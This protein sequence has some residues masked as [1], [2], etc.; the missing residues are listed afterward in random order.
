MKYLVF[1]LIVLFST[2]LLAQNWTSVIETEVDVSTATGV[3]DVFANGHGLHVIY[4]EDNALKYC[5]MDVEGNLYAGSP[6]TLESYSAVV[7]PSISGDANTIYVLYKKSGETSIK[8]MYSTN[9]GSN[10]STLGSSPTGSNADFIESIYSEGKLHVTWQVSNQVKYS[11]F[12]GSSWSSP[13]TVSSTENGYFPRIAAWNL[14]NE[15]KVYFYYQNSSSVSK[16]REYNITNNSWGNIQTAFSVSNSTPSGFAV[17]GSK[18]ALFYNYYDAPMYYFQWVIRSKSNNSLLCTRT[19]EPSYPQLLYSTTTVDEH[20]HSVFWFNWYADE[21]EFPG[22]WR[23]R[24]DDDCSIDEVYVNNY[25]EQQNVHFINTSA[26]SN[27]VYVIW[28]D[29]YIS[30]NL[31]LIYDDQ[32]PLVPQNLS[33]QIHSEGGATYPKLNWSFNN[34]PDVFIKTNAYQVWRRYNLSGG[35]WSDWSIIGYRDGDENQYIDYTVS[36]L[37]AEANTAEYKLKVR[38]YTNHFS[39]YSSSVSVNFSEFNKISL[40]YVLNEYGLKQNYPNPFNPTTT[41]SYSIKTA[42]LVTLK[43]YDVMGTEVASLINANKEAGKY[44][45]EFNAADLPSGIYFYTLTSG[46]FTATKKLILLK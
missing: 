22:I 34:E 24:G 5:R 36:G 8:T 17:D 26:S 4:Q 46:N 15:N 6:F 12:N 32:T 23:S 20:M 10:W 41:I 28:Q 1:I 35:P 30:D 18:I 25:Q 19:A 40:G 42:G 43:V 29:D 31:R 21:Q 27:D 39:D 11:N 13:Y 9:A 3:V 45:V 7:W 33:V 14:N 2:S 38:D 16:W 44:S 37:Y